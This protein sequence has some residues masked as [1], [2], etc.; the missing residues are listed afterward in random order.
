[1]LSLGFSLLESHRASF[2]WRR[3][4]HLSIGAEVINTLSHSPARDKSHP[5]ERERERDERG[6][7][8]PEESLQQMF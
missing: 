6:R 5:E 4:R 2:V 1:M 8:Y 7:N 3:R